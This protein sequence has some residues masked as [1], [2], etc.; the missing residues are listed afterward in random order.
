MTEY[1][2][3]VFKIRWYDNIKAYR[4]LVDAYYGLKFRLYTVHTKQFKQWIAM[5]DRINKSL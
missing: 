1:T 2:I 3:P 5:H 4:F